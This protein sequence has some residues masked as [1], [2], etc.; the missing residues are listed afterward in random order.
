MTFGPSPVPRADIETAEWPDYDTAMQRLRDGALDVLRIVIVGLGLLVLMITIN[1]VASKAFGYT[2]QVVGVTPHA[3]INCPTA[4]GSVQVTTTD[5]DLAQSEHVGTLCPTGKY[6]GANF[7]YGDER[8]N[9]D[10]FRDQDYPAGGTI[11]AASD[12]VL[13]WIPAR[14][15]A[16]IWVTLGVIYVMRHYLS[17]QVRR[18][19]ERTRA[20]RR[21]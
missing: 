9:F 18:E 11:T 8:V 13:F 17:K 16:L 10:N 4:N 6:S 5:M 14:A 1:L 3:V 19:Y 7:Y 12:G 15:F 20:L 21:Q 2:E